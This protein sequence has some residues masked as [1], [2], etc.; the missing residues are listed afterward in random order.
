MADFFERDIAVILLIAACSVLIILPI[1]LILCF[2]AKK[3]LIKL[4][5]SILLTVLS[6]TFYIMAL[7]AKDWYGFLYLIISVF[8]GIALAFSGIA[9]GIEIIIKLITKRNRN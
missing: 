1:Q 8:S 4:I 9:W 3:L 2:K 7:T 6:I 5:P